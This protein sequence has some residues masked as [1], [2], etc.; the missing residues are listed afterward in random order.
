MLRAWLDVSTPALWRAFVDRLLLDASRAG[1]DAVLIASLNSKDI[2]I[3]EATVWNFVVRLAQGR[4]VPAAVLDAALPVE[5]Q[6]PPAGVTW[7]QFG[8]ELIARQHAG[9]QTPD[10]AA[11]VTSEASKHVEDSQAL[12]VIPQ[13]LNQSGGLCERSS[14][15]FLNGS[16]TIAPRHRPPAGRTRHGPCRRSGQAC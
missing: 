2:G 7:E 12:A 1:Q 15:T 8:R 10:R 9:Q 14:D 13:A 6:D 16:L 11:L 4:P 5:S 3:R